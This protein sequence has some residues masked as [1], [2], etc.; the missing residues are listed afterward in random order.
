[1]RGFACM[2]PEKLREVA[3]RGGRAQG[4]KTNPGNFAHDPK[5]AAKAGAKGGKAKRRT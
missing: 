5:R 4:K 2:S 1:M 3:A